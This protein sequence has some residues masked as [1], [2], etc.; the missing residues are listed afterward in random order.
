MRDLFLLCVHRYTVGL[1]TNEQHSN[2]K[3]NRFKIKGQ[4]RKNQIHT[5]HTNVVIEHRDKKKK[6]E[7][8]WSGAT[9]MYE[10]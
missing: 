10:L 7:D 8:I 9:N 2:S 1:V 3:E 5:R 4:T 6:K